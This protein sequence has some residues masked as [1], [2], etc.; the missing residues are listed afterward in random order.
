MLATDLSPDTA[1]LLGSIATSELHGVFFFRI[2]RRAL[3]ASGS[4]CHY[5]VRSNG[6]KP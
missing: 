6:M 2:A 4:K 1:S 5:H 3:Y